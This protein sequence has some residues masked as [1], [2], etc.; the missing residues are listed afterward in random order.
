M[1]SNDFVKYLTVEFVERIQNPK[2]KEVKIP[3]SKGDYSTN[4]FGIIPLSIKMFAK[5]FQKN[6]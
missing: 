6:V 3:K 2:T 5:K 1:K 4:W